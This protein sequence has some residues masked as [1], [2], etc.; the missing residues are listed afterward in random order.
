MEMYSTLIYVLYATL[1]AVAGFL[2]WLW[3][4]GAF[5]TDNPE[6]KILF[7]TNENSLEIQK[8]P[9]QDCGSLFEEL[10]N[11]A[12]KGL[13]AGVYFDDPKVVSPENCRYGVGIL[14][15][16]LTND[17][18]SRL[19][20]HTALDLPGGKIV[21]ATYPW[22]GMVSIYFIVNWVYPK[23]MPYFKNMDWT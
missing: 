12:P 8:G 4:Q 21:E 7:R 6:T 23:F 19:S 14:D 3:Y 13:C 16:G 18:K 11:I 5:D 17:Q 10:M 1:F 20:Q 2:L 15:R 9:Y 22:F